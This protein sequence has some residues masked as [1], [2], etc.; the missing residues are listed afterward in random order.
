MRSAAVFDG[1]RLRAE[2]SAL[3]RRQRVAFAATC[4]EVLIPWYG[5]FA[6]L[7]GVGDP[8]FVRAATDAVWSQL[9]Q[10]GS[11]IDPAR[12]PSVATIKELLPQEEDWNEWAPQAE[13]TVA[14]LVFLLELAHTD[15]VRFAVYAARRTY[16]AV[17]ELAARQADLCVLDAAARSALLESPPVQT[18]LRRQA[19]VL[20]FL[21][22][23]PGDNLAQLR[24]PAQGA[25]S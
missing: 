21:R 22:T 7:E 14:A 11:G 1:E 4:V 24:D 18:E 20:R 17:D 10:P 3:T 9:E 19:A 5:R 23:A 16:S 25:G 15:D 6:A 13:D 8:E 2:L 12:L